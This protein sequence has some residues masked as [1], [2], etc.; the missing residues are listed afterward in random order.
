M[1]NR[2]RSLEGTVPAQDSTA[3]RSDATDMIQP[4]SR[5]RHAKTVL[6]VGIVVGVIL[7]AI[8]APVL[9][10]YDP[11][12]LNLIHRLTPPSWDPAGSSKHLLG[13]DQ[14]G[15]DLLSRII[16]GARVSLLVGF[17]SVITSGVL[18]TLLG[19]IAGYYG[20]I[21]DTVIMRITDIQMALPFMLLAL[22]VVALL[23]PSLPNII[24]VFTI[25]AWYI[26]TRVSRA[27]TLS[28]REYQ[29]VEAAR[30]LGATDLRVLLRHVLPSLLSTLLVAAS[31]ESARIITTEA[32]L[33][34]LGLGV[35]PPTPTWGNML[36]DGREYIQNAWWISTFPGLAL[37][38][39][40][41]GINI[42]GDVLRDILDPGLST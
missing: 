1:P 18:G 28:V 3:G 39:T 22:L 27:S 4:G 6:G 15:R 35:P 12:K 30:A 23:G 42:L 21:L 38:I 16:Y 24:V 41:L 33:G 37:V 40:V 9:A 29:Y 13:T 36:S 34:F 25:T 7:V 32:A 5:W 20:G 14:L 26:Y 10:P 2:R 11:D 19:L 8:L 17:L 31:F